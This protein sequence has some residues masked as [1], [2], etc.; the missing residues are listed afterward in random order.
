[1]LRV[2]TP[3]AL[4]ASTAVLAQPAITIDVENPVLMPGESTVVTMYAGYG[5]TDYAVAGVYTDFLAP[6]G[7]EGWTGVGLVDPMDGPGTTAGTASATGYDEIVAG[8]LNFPSG[9]AIYAD[10]TNPIAFWQAT[11]I[12]P[13]DVTEPFDLHVSTMTRQ[14]DVYYSRLSASSESRLADLAEGS[15]TIRVIPAPAS[16]LVLA[17]GLLATRRRR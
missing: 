13:L 15:A 6:G 16:A 17:C 11:Y 5:G 14:Y 4:V 12:A 10:P 8:Q 2:A 7:S 9:A 3:I 1:M